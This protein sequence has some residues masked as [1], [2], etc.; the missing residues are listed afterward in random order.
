MEPP[1]LHPRDNPRDDLKPERIPT[2]SS[3]EISPPE[4]HE[5]AQRKPR[6]QKKECCVQAVDSGER[7]PP[8]AHGRPI[9]EGHTGNSST[10]FSVA[11]GLAAAVGFCGATGRGC[12]GENLRHLQM[13]IA[14]F[15]LQFHLITRS[16]GSTISCLLD[17]P[18]IMH[19]TLY[20]ITSVPLKASA[21]A[22]CGCTAHLTLPA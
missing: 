21:A 2:Y 10:T 7:T 16:K 14:T 18:S 1:A 12:E 19:A 9:K 15:L 3:G 20:S 22:C 13:N 17:K 4:K 5:H 6:D 11:S 8:M